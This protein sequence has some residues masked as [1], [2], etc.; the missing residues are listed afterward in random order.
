MPIPII[1]GAVASIPTLLN[2]GS[3]V[4]KFY[5]RT[6]NL[7]RSSTFGIGYGAGTAVGFNLVPQFGRKKYNKQTSVNLDKR[8]PYNRTYSRRYS[9]YTS[10]YSRYPMRRR[11][12]R[13]PAYRRYY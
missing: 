4:G 12:Y 8:M 11:R 2:I 3:K 9:R 13:R 1:L 6:G 10:R 7:G 5:S